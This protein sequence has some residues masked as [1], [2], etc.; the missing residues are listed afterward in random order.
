LTARLKGNHRAHASPLRVSPELQ[1][2][3]RLLER[4]A[5]HKG[6]GGNNADMAAETASALVACGFNGRDAAIMLQITPATLRQRVHRTKERV[7]GMLRETSF[8]IPVRPAIQGNLQRWQGQDFD[9]HAEL[10]EEPAEDSANPAEELE[11]Q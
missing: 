8:S 10:S 7:M 9:Q 3:F 6:Y 4:I 11:E 5:G 1:A 2:V